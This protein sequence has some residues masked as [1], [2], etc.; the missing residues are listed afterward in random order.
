MKGTQLIAPVLERLAERGT[1]DF[2]YVEGVAAADM[3][4]LYGEAD[5]VLDQFR[6]GSYGVAACEAMAAGRVVVGHVSPAVRSHVLRAT[7]L[8]L[9]IVEATPDS[10]RGGADVRARRPRAPPTPSGPRPRVRR[11]RPR[12]PDVE[13]CTPPV[14]PG[15]PHV[16]DRSR[17]RLLILSFSPIVSDARLL[18]QVRRFRDDYAV[19]TCGYGDA[20]EV[21]T[22]TCGSP[23]MPPTTT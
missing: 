10:L 6:I 19:T 4:A 9:P 8:E 16:T 18:K 3:P 20:P 12:R 2:R 13:P 1:I 15:G 7:G 11:G 21:S 17:P 5:I 22:S 14:P 23:T